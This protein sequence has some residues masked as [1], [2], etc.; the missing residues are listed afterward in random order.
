MSTIEVEQTAESLGEVGQAEIDA[1]S[2]RDDDDVEG[3]PELVAVMSEP[4]AHPSLESIALHGGTRLAADGDPESALRRGLARIPVS[5]PARDTHLAGHDHE[6][7][8]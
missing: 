7:G 2:A 4:F 1:R 8:G 5:R 3:V 6:L